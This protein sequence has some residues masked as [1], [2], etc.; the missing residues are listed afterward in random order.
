MECRW[1]VA[2]WLGTTNHNQLVLMGSMI[3]IIMQ[4][5]SKPIVYSNPFCW[6]SFYFLQLDPK[7]TRNSSREFSLFLLKSKNS[8]RTISSGLQRKCSS[9]WP[10]DINWALGSMSSRKKTSFSFKT[11]NQPNNIMPNLYIHSKRHINAG[12]SSKILFAKTLYKNSPSYNHFPT[13]ILLPP[14]HILLYFVILST[15]TPSLMLFYNKSS[16][17]TN[18]F[19]LWTSKL[20]Y[21]W[22]RL[23]G[24]WKSWGRK[25]NVWRGS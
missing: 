24:Y 9:P 5:I 23:R 4:W 22:T 2:I 17:K 8:C 14:H 15:P 20:I 6:C 12:I 16:K 18:N 3:T 1:I 25:G 11:I 7:T 21:N 19:S 10:K 13:T